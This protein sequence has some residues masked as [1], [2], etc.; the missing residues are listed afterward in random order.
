MRLVYLR[1]FFY[2]ISFTT[3]HTESRRRAP[4]RTYAGITHH[5][6]PP[7]DSPCKRLLSINLTCR[8]VARGWTYTRAMHLA[9]GLYPSTRPKGAL[10]VDFFAGLV[11]CKGRAEKTTS[12]APGIP[13]PCPR[14]SDPGRGYRTSFQPSALFLPR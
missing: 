3:E 6:Y 10:H 14:F 4:V 12:V 1:V 13:Q 9:N 8:C 2:L 7:C 11:F 5:S